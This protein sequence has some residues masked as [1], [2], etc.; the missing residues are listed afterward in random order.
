MTNGPGWFGSI[1]NQFGNSPFF[2]W[3]AGHILVPF[4]AW[5]TPVT[6]QPGG[7]SFAVQP[8]E[9]IQR[10]MNL[11]M[12]LKDKTAIGRAK[13]AMAVGSNL[14]EIF[15]GLDNV[16]TVHNARFVIVDNNLCMFSAYDGDFANYIR[17]FIA[18]I[19][20]VFDGIVVL[21]EG[22]DAVI[23]TGHNIEAFI[24]WVEQRDMYQI[25]DIVTDVLRYAPHDRPGQP[26]M[27]DI[28]LR[29]LP[30]DLILQLNVNKNVALGS[31]YRG[32]PGF[33]TAF[34]RKQSG[35]GW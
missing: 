21:I 27:T 22:G 3:V 7:P 4:W 33:S 5:W 32:Y 25:P 19:G 18:Q 28:D 10:M 11:V 2:E 35:L 24:D 14:D 1:V 34:I 30:R 16:G 31:G 20:T 6:R 8:R 23:P 15:A 17:D 9:N 13:A 29:T 12:P 26:G